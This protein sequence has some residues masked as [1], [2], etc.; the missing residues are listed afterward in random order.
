MIVIY[1]L[2]AY[3]ITGLGFALYFIFTGA[4]KIHH[5]TR[6]GGFGLKLLLL[7]AAVMLWPYLLKRVMQ[8]K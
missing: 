5:S 3:L 8:K 1:L 6:E 2:D 7:P 4:E